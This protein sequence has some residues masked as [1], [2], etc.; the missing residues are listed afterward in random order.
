MD[1]F[2]ALPAIR[3]IRREWLLK[4]EEALAIRSQFTAQVVATSSN[5]Q[6]IEVRQSEFAQVEASAA[7]AQAQTVTARPGTQSPTLTIEAEVIPRLPQNPPSSNP[8][9]ALPPS[10]LP[11][12]RPPSYNP[13]TRP[14][15]YGP[16]SGAFTRP[17]SYNISGSTPSLVQHSHPFRSDTP[18]SYRST[19][20]S[21]PED[22][23]F[24]IPT[25]ASPTFPTPNLPEAPV[26]LSAAAD[27]D[28][29]V[30]QAE[31]GPEFEGNT[32]VAGTLDRTS[33]TVAQPGASIDSESVIGDEEDDEITPLAFKD[34]SRSV[35]AASTVINSNAP[36]RTPSVSSTYN[37]NLRPSVAN[38]KVPVGPFHLVKDKSAV[39]APAYADHNKD[40]LV[41][42][43][44]DVWNEDLT[45][46]ES[47]EVEKDLD[48]LGI[49]LLGG[50]RSSLLN[51]GIL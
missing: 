13:F 31:E 49:S 34:I 18:S 19:W 16:N 22:Q 25:E 4:Q 28:E 30:F 38:G 42:N 7:E 17:P 2:E 1:L 11:G 20:A 51:S 37:G 33:I 50:Q 35:S 10:P 47:N 44:K 23:T 12:S 45:G 9:N 41:S 43:I 14:P 21:Y 26:E 8:P 48:K 6:N 27:K 29:D 5:S 3:A 32:L 40:K 46:E 24:V 36:S 15:S 39:P